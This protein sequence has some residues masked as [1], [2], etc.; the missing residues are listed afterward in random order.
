[1]HAR[2]SASVAGLRPIVWAAVYPVPMATLMRPG[3]RSSTVWIALASVDTWR[4]SGLVTAENS[5][6]SDV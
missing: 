6:R 5:V 3:A 2:I 4:V 1:M